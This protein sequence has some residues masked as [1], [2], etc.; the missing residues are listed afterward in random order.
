MIGQPSRGDRDNLQAL[1]IEQVR[2]FHNDF[3]TG[4]NIVV[5]AS[6]NVNHAEIVSAVE[7][8]FSSLPKSSGA[9]IPNSEKPIY[10]PSLLFMR[11][12]EMI[13]SN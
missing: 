1:K 7:R 9:T 3:Y 5:V 8:Q 13:N 12:D 11:D 10:T 2:Q 6:G 4:E